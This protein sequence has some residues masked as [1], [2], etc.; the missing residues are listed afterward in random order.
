MT[1]YVIHLSGLAALAVLFV[2]VAPVY[3]L[4]YLASKAVSRWL[5]GVLERRFKQRMHAFSADRTEAEID[6]EWRRLTDR[7]EM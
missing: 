4:M 1:A 7:E 2:A 6:R 3:F 5:G